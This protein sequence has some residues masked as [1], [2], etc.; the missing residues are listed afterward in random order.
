MCTNYLFFS[1][2]I[3]FLPQISLLEK[4]NITVTLNNPVYSTLISYFPNFFSLSQEGTHIY[5]FRK[6]FPSCNALYK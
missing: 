1:D 3:A 4:T 5:K 2:I 6:I